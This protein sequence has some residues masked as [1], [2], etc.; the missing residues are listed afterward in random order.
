MG[1]EQTIRVFRFGDDNEDFLL[2]Y[3]TEPLEDEE[4]EEEVEARL[5]PLTEIEGE[6]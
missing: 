6:E 2:F 3:A 1:E 5:A 4:E